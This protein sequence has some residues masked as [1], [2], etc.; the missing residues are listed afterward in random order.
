M[1]NEEYYML[2]GKRTHI[3]EQ[4]LK[5]YHESQRLYRELQ[6]WLNELHLNKMDEV[7]V[8][9]GHVLIDQLSDSKKL[10][11]YWKA[12]EFQINKALDGQSKPPSDNP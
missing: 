10:E 11:A 3:K 9:R 1:T 7:R 5:A 2:L 12:E 4:L 6:S 8:A